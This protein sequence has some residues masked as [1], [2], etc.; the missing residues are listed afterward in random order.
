MKGNWYGLYITHNDFH[1]RYIARF[2]KET[3]EH[4]SDQDTYEPKL[5]AHIASDA[6]TYKHMVLNSIS[7]GSF[8]T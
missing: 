4:D 1:Q 5:Q 7:S 8:N 3:V 6:G 2:Q